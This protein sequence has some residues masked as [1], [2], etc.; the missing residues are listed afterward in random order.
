M[1]KPK[2]VFDSRLSGLPPS[3]ATVGIVDRLDYARAAARRLAEEAQEFV[4]ARTVHEMYNELVDCTFFCQHM[5]VALGVSRDTL[6][7]ASMV[8]SR[9]IEANPLHRDKANET[10]LVIN[11]ILEAMVNE[12][13]VPS[14]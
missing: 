9:A 12:R 7:R 2:F 11:A 6:D 8:K 3:T 13:P 10:R 4:D 1:D 5:M 14:N